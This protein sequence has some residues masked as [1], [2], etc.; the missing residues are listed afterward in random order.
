MRLVRYKYVPEFQLSDDRSGKVDQS[1]R[2]N[3]KCSLLVGLLELWYVFAP[4]QTQESR[5]FFF[6]LG[7]N[8][9]LA[10]NQTVPGF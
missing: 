8:L 3:G 2:E 6:F 10:L 7:A 4:K 1:W 9:H 5:I